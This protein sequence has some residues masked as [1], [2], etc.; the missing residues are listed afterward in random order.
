[1]PT[2]DAIN[3]LPIIVGLLG[4]LA[5][6]LFGMEQMT[7]SL[8]LLAGNRMKRLLAKMTTNRF[9]GMVVG[10]FVTAVIQSS[11]VTTV[12]VVGFISAGVMSLSQSVGVIMGAN[13]GTTVTAQVIAF[14]ITKAAL[15]MIALGYGAKMFG[16]SERLRESGT[17][18]F[19][20]GLIFFG[21][22]LMSEAAYP[23]RDYPPFIDLMREMANPLLGILAGA[24]VTAAVQSSS[25]TTGIVIVLASQ[26]AI[27][28]EAGIALIM[29]ANIGTCVTA[30]LAAIGKPREGVQAAVIHLLFNVLGVLLWIA[31]IPYLAEAVRGFSPVGDIAR[32]IANAHTLF[33]VSNTV[34]F[35]GFAGVFAGLARKLVP[36]QVAP[37]KMQPKYLDDIYLEAPTQAL[38]R[39][40]LELSRHLGYSQVMLE[41]AVRGAVHGDRAALDEAAEIEQDIDHLQ[42]AIL[43]FLGKVSEMRLSV[44]QQQHLQAAIAIANRIESMGDVVESDIIPSARNEIAREGSMSDGMRQALEVL[45]HEVCAVVKQLES[46]LPGFDE[47]IAREVVGR[48]RT[49]QRLAD[50][51]VQCLH[52]R[53]AGRDEAALK[54]FRY[55][56]DLIEHLKRQYYFSKQIAKSILIAKNKDS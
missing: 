26:S 43:Q 45:S 44:N 40:Y 20:L 5:L 52:G 29:G 34:V 36:A 10:A 49:V 33:N 39:S 9:S 23:L 53:L 19:G 30:M 14:K 28:L 54:R 2:S 8:K 32:Q 7:E 13:I 41:K 47:T 55:E 31:F 21:M 18:L 12:L 16:R 27:T 38:D 15:V 42:A 17:M 11:S 25:A 56:A 37:G 50:A 1:M 46:A 48:K 6:F 24:L 4:G 51:A 3:W 22:N 35:I